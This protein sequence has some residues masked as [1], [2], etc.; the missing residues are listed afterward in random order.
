MRFYQYVLCLL[1]LFVSIQSFSQESTYDIAI[2]KVQIIDG[3]GQAAFFGNVLI[4]DGQIVTIQKDTSATLNAIKRVNGRGKILTPGFIDTHSHGDPLETPEFKNF[5]AMGVT[6]ICL[7]Q[8]GF[9]PA[10]EDLNLWMQKVSEASPAVNIAMFAGHNTLRKLSGVNFDTVPKKENMLK[11][12]ELLK[13]AMDAGCFG[14]TTGLEY[15]PGFYARKK[16]LQRLAKIVG[17]KKGIIMSHMR[18]EDDSE[19]EASIEELLAQGNYCP[20]HI[21]HIKVVYGKGKERAEEILKILDNARRE[22]KII[23]ADIYPYMASYTGI[24]ILFPHWA[25]EPNVYDEVVLNRRK[26]LNS[27]L[28]NIV[29]KRNGPDAILFGS[30]P[31]SGKTLA[32]VAIELEKPFEEVL[33]ED[34]GP[35]GASGAYFVMDKELQERILVNPFVN[36][37]TDGSPGMR[38]PRGY[39]SFVKVIETYVMKDNLFSM[40]EAV[41]KMS[42]LPAEIIGLPNRGLIK[43]G[44]KADLLVFDPLHIK[45]RA[46]YETPHQLA[47]GMD[48][49][50]V[51]GK[52]AK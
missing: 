16:E 37:C 29:V 27:Y 2:E 46:T 39:A 21:S 35:T 22:G 40:E 52:I 32:E 9:S 50:I 20:V 31:F 43:E 12:E 11:M 7:G 15:N 10:E 24:G 51:N 30:G 19:V 8:D 41:Y 47:E 14:M 18:D 6:S 3:T 17:E 36:I 1:L 13:R 26:E 28:K 42:G 44:Y 49:V 38:H 25:K 4:R 5:L 34:I 33:M 23:T 45:E 48:L